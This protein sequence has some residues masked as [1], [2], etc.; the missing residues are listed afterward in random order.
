MADRTPEQRVT[1]VLYGVFIAITAAFV[2]STI[3]Q[4]STAV[5]GA[6]ERV[7]EA[8]A[9][10]LSGLEK[11]VDTGGDSKKKAWEHY[12]DVEK[13]CEADPNGKSALAAL[14]RYE[15]AAERQRGDLGPVRRAV[16]SFIK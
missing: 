4:V 11:A 1:R 16:E 10:G 15:R 8:C 12:S 6:H 5:F 7:G 2:V 9:Q 3:V 13:T 14:A